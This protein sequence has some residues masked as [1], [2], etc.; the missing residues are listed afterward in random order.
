MVAVHDAPPLVG[1]DDTLATLR[2]ALVQA[3]G[4]HGQMLVGT[5]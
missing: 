5:G 4:Q 2:E 1:R 3:A